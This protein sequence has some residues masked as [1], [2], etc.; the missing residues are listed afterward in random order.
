METVRKEIMTNGAMLW[1]TRGRHKVSSLRR[2]SIAHCNS[3]LWSSQQVMPTRVVY[4]RVHRESLNDDKVTT[5]SSSKQT[6]KWKS[7]QFFSI[8]FPQLQLRAVSK[9]YL[10][11]APTLVCTFAPAK[12]CHASIIQ[13]RLLGTRSAGTRLIDFNNFGNDLRPHL[14][15]PSSHKFYIANDFDQGVGVCR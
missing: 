11:I 15:F 2:H 12:I 4:H 8:F 5:V 1:L 13:F 3:F 14:N 9:F 10:F 7:Q 6:F